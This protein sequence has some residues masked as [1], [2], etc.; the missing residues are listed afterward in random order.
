MA[1]QNPNTGSTALPGCGTSYSI[2]GSEIFQNTIDNTNIAANTIG[3]G[4]VSTS[5]IQSV[6]VQVAN[7]DVV[8][9][10]DL[11]IQLIA[12]PGS[13]KSIF[14]L[15]AF[16]RYHYGVHAF[17]AGG[18]IQLQ[19][20][21]TTHAGGTTPFA[22]VPATALTATSDVDSQ[23]SASGTSIVVPQN[24]G[25]FFANATQDFALAGGSTST[26]F[27]TLKYYIA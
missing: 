19:Y 11:G 6:T 12:A 7:T 17:T 23:F 8:T 15:D 24:K 25:I 16:I 21:S 3:S 4:Q 13:G 2:H 26:V 5:L 22:T 10:Y 20:D 14:L 27:V 18:V 9:A 1:S